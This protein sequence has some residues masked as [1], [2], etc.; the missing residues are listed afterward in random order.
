MHAIKS[1]RRIVFFLGIS[2]AFCGNSFAAPVFYGFSYYSA[3][4]G[5]TTTDLPSFVSADIAGASGGSADAIVGT[6]SFTGISPTGESRAMAASFEGRWQASYSGLKSL[7]SLSVTDGFTAGESNTPYV[8]DWGVTDPSGFPG[9][10]AVQTLAGMIDLLSVNG[11]DGLR[12]VRII[13]RI[14]GIL[15]GGSVQ[16]WQDTTSLIFESAGYSQGLSDY[17]VVSLDIPVVN[18]TAKVDLAL[19]TA[20]EL[21]LS[22]GNFSVETVSSSDFFNTLRIVGISGYGS[23]GQQV[24]LSSVTGSDGTSLNVQNSNNNTVPEPASIA[25]V[26]IG[27]CLALRRY[28]P[29]GCA[30]LDKIFG[31]SESI[32]RL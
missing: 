30:R 15:S 18:G 32:E 17:S 9:G 8:L 29:G 31:G 3:S 5:G 27:M 11:A 26:A 21:G 16:V 12:F 4:N 7:A 19:R 13:M 25:L 6:S 14:D 22:S 10:L 20:A 28:Q 23:S 2:M 1:F 24:S